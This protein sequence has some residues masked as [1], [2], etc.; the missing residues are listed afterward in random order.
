MLPFLC[1]RLAILAVQVH[2]DQRAGDGVEAGRKYDG[3]ELVFVSVLHDQAVSRHFA[4]RVGP[5]A[6]DGYII[7]IERLIVIG[8]DRRPLGSDRMV[9]VAQ[10]IGDCRIVDGVTDLRFDIASD[11]GVRLQV[12]D[13]IVVAGKHETEAADFPK[14]VESGLSLLV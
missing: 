6:D 8:V 3:V 12:D 14:F 2:L 5:D 4:D 10:D 9:E 1:Q 11:G 13:D 7:P